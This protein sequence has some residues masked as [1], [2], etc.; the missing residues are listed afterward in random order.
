MID[1][2][3]F[4]GVIRSY[5]DS[6]DFL[7]NTESIGLDLYETPLCATL[8]TIFDTWLNSITNDDGVDLIYWWLFEDVEKNIYKDEEVIAT[9]TDEE[10]LY[11]YMKE[12]GIYK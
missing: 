5:K 7:E 3:T 1:K 4:I 11:N 12:N 2:E 6:M 9:L 10:S 8:D